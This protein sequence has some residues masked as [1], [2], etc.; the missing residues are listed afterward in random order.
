V[1]TKRAVRRGE[2]ASR[3]VPTLDPVGARYAHKELVRV[4]EDV[5]VLHPEP[6]WVYVIGNPGEG[7]TGAAGP[8]PYVG[9]KRREP[10]LWASFFTDESSSEG[11]RTP[12]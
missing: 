3:E 1:R 10:P 6:G 9:P 8:Y 7:S 5:G 4:T 2:R 11:Q 12:P